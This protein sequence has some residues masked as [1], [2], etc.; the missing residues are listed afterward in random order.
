[1][2]RRIVVCPSAQLCHDF[3]RRISN[4]AAI[5]EVVY[6][7]LWVDFLLQL[8]GV[9]IAAILDIRDVAPQFFQKLNDFGCFLLGQQVDLELKVGPLV[10]DPGEP[11]LSDQNGYRDQGAH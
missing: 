9:L 3:R 1:M 8:L 10:H 2:S 6:D 11:V 4:A 5:F 7:A